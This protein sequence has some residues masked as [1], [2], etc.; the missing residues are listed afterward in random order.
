MALLALGACRS[1][2]RFLYSWL[3]HRWRIDFLAC[4]GGHQSNGRI[5][6]WLG[7]VVTPTQILAVISKETPSRNQSQVRKPGRGFLYDGCVDCPSS[8]PRGG[9]F[10]KDRPSVRLL[11]D[12]ALAEA[13]LDLGHR[14]ELAECF[15]TTYSLGRSLRPRIRQSIPTNRFSSLRARSSWN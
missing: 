5:L 1:N 11:R 10:R 14:D 6:Y 13:R 3:C 12:A 8:P 15:A 2:P 9:F 4:L 7:Q